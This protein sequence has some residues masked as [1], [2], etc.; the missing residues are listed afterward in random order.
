[1]RIHGHVPQLERPGAFNDSL[2][3]FLAESGPA[4]A[5]EPV[6]GGVLPRWHSRPFRVGSSPDTSFDVKNLRQ[7]EDLAAKYG[8]RTPRRRAFR[9][10]T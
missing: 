2:T 1:M 10:G 3:D 5:L 8:L 4:E 9:A 7:V 6:P